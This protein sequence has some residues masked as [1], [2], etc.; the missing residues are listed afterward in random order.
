MPSRTPGELAGG[1][2]VAIFLGL[3]DKAATA[4]KRMS[5]RAL[6]VAFAL[7]GAGVAID[8]WTKSWAA[9]RLPNSPIDVIRGALSLAY[10]E[11]KNAAFGLFGFLPDSVKAPVLLALTSVLTIVLVVAMIKST[12]LASQIGFAATV[13]GA[14]GNIID[15]LYLHYVRDFIYW[16]GGFQWPNFN[17][18][19]MLVCTGVA[20]LVVLGGRSKKKDEAAAK[21]EPAKS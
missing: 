14:L 18:A 7:I 12:D 20:I 4:M 6:A 17:V 1:V 10:V 19:D 5:N 3:N 8:Q 9:H 11:N 16:H 2:F 15:R 21:A 13:S